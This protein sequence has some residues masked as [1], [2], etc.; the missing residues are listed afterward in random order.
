LTE[1][2]NGALHIN[3]GHTDAIV[4]VAE[5][6]TQQAKIAQAAGNAEIAAAAWTAATAA[7]MKALAT[8]EA[9]GNLSERCNIRYNFACC[10][11]KC[12]RLPEAV[13]LLGQLMAAGLVSAAD[14]AQDPDLEPIR[15]M[16]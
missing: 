4:G 15:G 9:L 2:Y 1:G 14:V 13:H 10:L 5:A 7:Y 16:F 12:G 6:Q 8:P 3:S 11:V